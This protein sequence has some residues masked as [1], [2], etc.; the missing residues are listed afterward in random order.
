MISNMHRK[1]SVKGIGGV[2]A[3]VVVT[4]QRG[5]VWMSI[6]PPFAWEAIMEPEKVD[7]LIHTLAVATN[8]AKK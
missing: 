2:A 8:S 3:T 5:Q 6:H 1:V 7:E 4:V